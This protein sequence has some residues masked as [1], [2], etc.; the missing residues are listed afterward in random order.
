MDVSGFSNLVES[1]ANR[2]SNPQIKAR[3]FE[4]G[5][6]REIEKIRYS[7]NVDRR[8]N[9]DD[10]AGKVAD[11]LSRL[12]YY[13]DSSNSTNAIVRH[14]AANTADNSTSQQG[15]GLTSYA[16]EMLRQERFGDLRVLVS[17]LQ[18]GHE[19]LPSADA[20]KFLGT[21]DPELGYSNAYDL[22]YF[23][24]AIRNGFETLKRE[25]K[26]GEDL[27]VTMF[28]IVTAGGTLVPGLNIPSKAV[29]ISGSGA[30][31]KVIANGQCNSECYR[32]CS[33]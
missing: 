8:Y 7:D 9:P 16:A 32:R 27:A 21:K 28:S 4:I 2:T 3:V 20:T 18:V 15:D 13:G 23:M 17:R 31:D 33:Q 22:G 5:A 26:D 19:L 29:L 1:V 10:T 11:C 25:G 24:G 6:R 30:S 14:L 12:L